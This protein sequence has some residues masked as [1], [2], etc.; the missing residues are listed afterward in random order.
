MYKIRYSLESKNQIIDF[1]NLY[2][3]NFLS[4]F[5]NTGLFYEDIIRKNYIEISKKF[6]SEIFDSIGDKLIQDK[7]LWCHNLWN[8]NYKISLVVN[9]YRVFVVYFED[10]Q[11]NIRFIENI[12]IVRK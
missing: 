1:I 8:N 4:I 9:N 3:N 2:K 10:K 7:V 11:Y 12:K 6:K 5:S